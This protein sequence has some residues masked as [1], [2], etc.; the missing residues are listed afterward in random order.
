LRSFDQGCGDE[1]LNVWVERWDDEGVLIGQAAGSRDTLILIDADGSETQ[2]DSGLP[3]AIEPFQID[4]ESI[5][6]VSYSPG[7]A[8][9]ALV[10]Y[11]GPRVATVRVV[12]PESGEVLAE[13]TEPGSNAFALAWSTDGR[14]LI[15][16][17]YDVTGSATLVFYDTATNS[18]TTIPIAD[19]VDQIRTAP[20]S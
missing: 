15:F 5:E 7:G 18:I 16:Q 11:P 10:V 17:Q 14:F 6:A 1:E 20:A 19:V 9:V 4:G 8:L 3:A 13:V 2:I 12:N